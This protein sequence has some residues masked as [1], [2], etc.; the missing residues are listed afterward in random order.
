MAKRNDVAQFRRHQKVVA[1]TDLP[2]VPAGT[3]GKVLL[4]NGLSWIRYHVLFDNGVERS[5]VR[6][7]WLMT[8]DDWDKAQRAAA[9][10]RR[11][12]ELDAERAAV[13]SDTTA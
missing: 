2:D 7:E 9:R 6:N 3:K 5:G 8:R 10:A 11:R 12:A 4:V 1:A 13:L